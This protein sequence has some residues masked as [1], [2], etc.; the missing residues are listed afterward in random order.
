MSLQSRHQP[1]RN[2]ISRMHTNMYEIEADSWVVGLHGQIWHR[3]Q[4]IPPEHRIGQDGEQNPDIQGGQHGQN[5]GQGLGLEGG[6]D[7]GAERGSGRRSRR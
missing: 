7:Q 2:A 4:D 3:D 6:R 5:Q 1:G